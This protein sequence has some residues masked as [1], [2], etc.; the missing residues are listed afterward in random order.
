MKKL[1]QTLFLGLG[2]LPLALVSQPI[3]QMQQQNAGVN[4][5]TH[6]PEAVKQ[7]QSSGKPIVV[8]FTGTNWCPACMKLEK[9]V[10]KK[11]EFAGAVGSRFIFLKAEFPDSSA[12][13][14]QASPYY[15]LLERYNIETF[16][17]LV[18]IDAK[19]QRL[20]TVGYQAGGP[21]HYINKMM[22][23][24]SGRSPVTHQ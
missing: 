3:G 24:H 9:E 11:P 14:V 20:N 19:G 15:S 2:F 12:E 18:I 8:L 6:Y 16:P 4:W 17:T 21:S 10:L 1:F 13:S 7:S 5:L 23:M 22:Q